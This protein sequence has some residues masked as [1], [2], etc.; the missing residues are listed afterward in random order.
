MSRSF[1]VGLANRFEICE[2]NCTR[3]KPGC[4]S[5]CK[6]YKE[7]RAEYDKRKAIVDADREVRHYMMETIDKRRND[8][9]K[10]RRDCSGYHRLGRD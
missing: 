8:N 6:R 1:N 2:P 9:V 4:H 10:R 3:R 5:H 7:R